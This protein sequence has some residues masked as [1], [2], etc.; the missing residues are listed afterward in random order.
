MRCEKDGRIA[1]L[2]G[3]RAYA[4]LIVMGF[5]LW[6]QS[7]LQGLFPS[8]L[9][10]PLGVSHFSLT[11]IPRTGY[12]FV[13]VLLLLSGLCLF[14]PYAR[15]MTNPLSPAPEKIGVYFKKRAARILPAYYLCLLVYLVLWVRPSDYASPSAYFLDV[16]SHLTFTHTFFPESY[17]ATKFPSTLWTLGIEIQFYLVFPLLA[18][19]FRR[20]PLQCWAALSLLA[21]L[22]ISFFAKTPDG[23]A[24]RLRINQ[25]PA[26]LGVYANGMLAAVLLYMLRARIPAKPK[27][28]TALLST[29]LCFAAYAA[30]VCML[31]DGLNR[32]PVIQR[33]QVDFRFWFSALVCVFILALD[34]AC[35]ALQWLFANPLTSFTALISYNLY[36]WH[37]T[38][39]LKL[40]EWRIP[41][42]PD[43][44]EGVSA[45]PQSAN[46]KSW[47]FTWQVQ[48]TVLFWLCAFLL[49]ALMTYLV[50]K[51]LA[52]RILKRKGKNT[53]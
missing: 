38:V 5:H 41:P 45:W 49:A 16:F 34:H 18:R 12:M 2:D 20:F 11:W 50:E 15:Q 23:G 17:L 24:E 37:A 6:Q 40:K 47:H 53:V 48:Y 32:A 21:E 51:P 10:R 43:A 26:F 8:D 9:L 33:W 3:V 35:R 19:L 27:R 30:L 42:Y 44:P 7:W 28:T 14:L 46:G 39:L 25:F 22:Y 36:L 1:I 31:K 13:D 29:L 52:R 4:I